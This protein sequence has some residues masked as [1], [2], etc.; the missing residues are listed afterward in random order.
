MGNG[1]V[2]TQRSENINNFNR[3]TNL[4]HKNNQPRL[5]YSGT[6]QRNSRIF[7]NRNKNYDFDN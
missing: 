7:N 4:N 1:Q 3:N 2:H 6:G 5:P